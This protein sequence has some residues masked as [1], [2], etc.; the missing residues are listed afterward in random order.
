MEWLRQSAEVTKLWKARKSEFGARCAREIITRFICPLT[1]NL[2]YE[3]KS[4]PYLYVATRGS[5]GDI[6]G[7]CVEKIQGSRKE[8][9]EMARCDTR[10]VS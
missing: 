8:T 7:R 4:K 2:W 6:K 10:G 5:S 3:V 9:A 1:R